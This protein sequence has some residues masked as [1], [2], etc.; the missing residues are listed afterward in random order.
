MLIEGSTKIDIFAGRVDRSHR[1]NQD[2]VDALP[3]SIVVILRKV[4]LQCTWLES[5]LA[6]YPISHHCGIDKGSHS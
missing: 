1:L 6:T 2:I 4:I 3:R 5:R